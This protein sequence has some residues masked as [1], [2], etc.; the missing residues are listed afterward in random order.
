M[1]FDFSLDLSWLLTH[2][3]LQVKGVNKKE[4]KKI[5]NVLTKHIIKLYNMMIKYFPTNES[6][7]LDFID[8][9]ILEVIEEGKKK[10]VTQVYFSKKNTNVIFFTVRREDMQKS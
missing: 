8:F 3:F 6:I 7:W 2:F 5:E 4:K 1:S 9:M 10:K